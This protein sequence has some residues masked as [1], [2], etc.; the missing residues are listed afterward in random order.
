V[1]VEDRLRRL[2]MAEFEAGRVDQACL[3]QA[4]GGAPISTPKSVVTG[5]PSDVPAVAA[6]SSAATGPIDPGRRGRPPTGP[7]WLRAGISHAERLATDAA[8]RLAVGRV[9]F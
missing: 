1:K 2:A 9:L 8:Y 4:L 5:E 6:P 7:E 3:N